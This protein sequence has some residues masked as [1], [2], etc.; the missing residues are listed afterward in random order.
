[1]TMKTGTCKRIDR[2][3]CP[4]LQAALVAVTPSALT[5]GAPFSPALTRDQHWLHAAGHP[6]K[7]LVP[8]LL[9][10]LHRVRGFMA[11]Q[12]QPFAVSVL[13]PFLFPFLFFF[14]DLATQLALSVHAASV[15]V[16]AAVVVVAVVVVVV[17]VVAVVVVVGAVV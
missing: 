4:L 1:M 6:A 14:L 13:F 10:V 11:T 3:A 8:P 7:A 16:G 12:L 9:L 15:V 5:Y 17:V 2:R